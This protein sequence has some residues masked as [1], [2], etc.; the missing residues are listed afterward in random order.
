MREKILPVLPFLLPILIERGL[1]FAGWTSLVMSVLLWLIAACLAYWGY[2]HPVLNKKYAKYMLPG[3]L[4]L[5]LIIFIVFVTNDKASIP[6]T[7]ANEVST[8]EVKAS[9]N[10]DGDNWLR[11]EFDLQR[12]QGVK[13]QIGS[14]PSQIEFQLL[15]RLSKNSIEVQEFSIDGMTAKESKVHFIWGGVNSD[16]L[17]L[18]SRKPGLLTGEIE[19][20]P[21]AFVEI[22]SFEWDLRITILSVDVQKLSILLEKKPGTY[23]PRALYSQQLGCK[24]MKSPVLSGD[25][26]TMP[27]K[28]VGK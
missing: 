24:F 28:K 1:D 9:R 6:K 26:A 20:R 5:S 19:L 13:V 18:S 4:I 2:L 25:F 8:E 7:N 10:I 3:V 15:R 22:C 11:Q 21:E 23:H 27:S 12:E 14:K 16:F 17:T